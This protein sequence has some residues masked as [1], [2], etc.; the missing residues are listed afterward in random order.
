MENKKPFL[1]LMEFANQSRKNIISSIVLACIGVSVGM[2]SYL[3]VAKLLENFYNNTE[4][5]ESILIWCIVAIVAVVLKNLFTTLST[6]KSHEAAFTILKN[7]RVKLAKKMEKVPMGVMIET[8]TGTL[9]TMVVDAV[10]KIEKPL[11]HLLPEMTSNILAPIIIIC[12]L[13]FVDWR[14]ALATIITIPIGFFISMGQMIGYKEKSELYYNANTN[15]NDAI[16][17]YVNGIQVIKAFNQSA[18]SYGKF[19]RACNNYCEITL[20]WWKSC[21]IFSAM[22]NSMMASTIVVTLPLGSYLFMNKSIDFSSFIICVILSMGISGPILATINFLDSIANIMESINQVGYF[23][24]KEELSRPSKE[25]VLNGDSFELKNVN[26]GYDNKQVLYDINLKTVPN[27]ITAI[28]GNSGGGKSTIA[29]LM[30]GFWD[31]SEGE[32]RLGGKNLK[33]IPV[34]QLMEN[35]S[36][37]SQDNYLFDMS[38]M[39]NI[40]MGDKN[41]TDE[42]I[43]KVSKICGCH[44]FILDFEDGY[45]TNV[46]DAGD[47]LSGGEKQRITLARA[48]LKKS[49][50]IIL[51]EATAYAD[52]E[53][54]FEIQMA[55]SEL[56]KKK[57]LIVIAHRLSTIKHADKI[58]VLNKGKIVSQ[59][60]HSDL[61]KN[62][63]LYKSMWNKHI[64][65]NN[66]GGELVV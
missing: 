52:P 49:K 32:V 13:F 20:N 22:G 6:M 54:E 35:I 43:I 40:R 66:E 14:M 42:E 46:G 44:K 34:K 51:D 50:I 56:I 4:N 23:L 16:I 39:E 3:S 19:T 37:V 53:N 10:D 18:S 65:V 11:A 28:V 57:T 12:I 21:W 41:A 55:I 8:P 38:I 26:F 47:R 29:K 1:R 25:A 61:V 62:C 45:N 64:S 2:F 63:S 31:P 58:V 33:Q 36:F 15:M 30:A 17:E 5:L 59:G 7:I 9:K 48:M 60:N 24:D 27:G